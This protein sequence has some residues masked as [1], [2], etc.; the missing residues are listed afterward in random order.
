MSRDSR[1]GRGIEPSFQTWMDSATRVLQQ[2]TRLNV[3][4]INDIEGL[5]VAGE[6]GLQRIA[7]LKA[8][9]DELKV[10][11][12]YLTGTLSQ[13]LNALDPYPDSLLY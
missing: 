2:N 6:R 10:Y 1:T 7:K 8:D 4:R 5:R 13:I 3:D 12:T 9:M 11:V